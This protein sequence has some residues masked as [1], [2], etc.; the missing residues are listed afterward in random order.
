MVAGL[1]RFCQPTRLSRASSGR[2][3]ATQFADDGR[4]RGDDGK[5]DKGKRNLLCHQIGKCR[6]TPRLY[7]RAQYAVE[8]SPEIGIGKDSRQDSQK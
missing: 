4:Y 2:F 7:R 3:V 1:A 5:R 8:A 6:L